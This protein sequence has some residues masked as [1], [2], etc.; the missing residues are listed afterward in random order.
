MIECGERVIDYA[1]TRLPY[2]HAIVNIVEGNLQVKV[3]KSPVQ[4]FE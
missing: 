4:F 1:V 3:V 2:S